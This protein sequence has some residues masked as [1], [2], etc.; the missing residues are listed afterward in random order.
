[1][2][3]QLK[4][5]RKIKQRI[6][7]LRPDNYAR[8][9]DDEIAH[10]IHKRID[11]NDYQYIHCVDN[12]TSQ[13]CL[14]IKK[15]INVV[16][17]HSRIDSEYQFEKIK[18]IDGIK[19]RISAIELLIK[20]R[21]YE[22]RIH[23]KHG[24]HIVCSNEDAQYL[25]SHFGKTSNILTIVNGFDCDIF[26]Q[27]SR[28]EQRDHKNLLFTGAMDYQPNIDAMMWFCHDIFRIL[29]RKIRAPSLI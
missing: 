23:E 16:T 3:I 7:D 5:W 11:N 29:L 18:Y 17:D 12:C 6:F 9:Y 28:V 4:A 8:W 21:W 1:M 19:A 26:Q 27:C 14:P 15:D 22:K 2:P 25:H 20:T 13:Y 10:F 24:N